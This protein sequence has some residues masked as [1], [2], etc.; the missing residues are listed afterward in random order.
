MRQRIRSGRARAASRMALAARKRAA[1]HR[2]L[3]KFKN[4]WFCGLIWGAKGVSCEGM[5]PQT[6]GGPTPHARRCRCCP[7]SLSLLQTPSPVARVSRP[8][9]HS[10]MSSARIAPVRSN[11]RSPWRAASPSVSL[12]SSSPSHQRGSP[13]HCNLLLLPELHSHA[14]GNLQVSS[15]AALHLC[16]LSPSCRRW[17]RYTPSSRLSPPRPRYRPRA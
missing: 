7:P 14:G 11:P 17:R 10:P 16:F 5:A 3:P 2:K 12:R 13:A 8:Y 9:L 4:P 6:F 15:P 1:R